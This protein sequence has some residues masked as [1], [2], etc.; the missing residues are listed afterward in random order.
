LAGVSFQIGELPSGL[1]GEESGK[2]IRIDRDA[3][4]YG[5]FV[6]PTPADD[7]EFADPSGTHS[8]VARKGT[9]AYG[10]A[11]LLTTVMHEMEHV[12]GYPDDHAMIDDL[13]AATLPTGVRRTLAVDY[14]LATLNDK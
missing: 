12:L 13:M 6:D 4:G 14:A 1:L 3:A 5:W 7:S 10:R 8:L 2:T 9:I 11:D